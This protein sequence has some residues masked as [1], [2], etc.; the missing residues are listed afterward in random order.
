MNT[1]HI[2]H[3]DTRKFG[4]RELGSY[5]VPSGGDSE[6][7]SRPPSSAW[8]LRGAM[9]GIVVAPSPVDADVLEV[10]L[11]GISI[12][13]SSLVSRLR[14]STCTFSSSSMSAATLQW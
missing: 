9:D 12:A 14:S 2:T 5:S 1:M 10:D 8:Q 4:T 7:A 6:A 13:S 3:H 11:F